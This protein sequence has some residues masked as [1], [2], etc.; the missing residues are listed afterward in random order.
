M[1]TNYLNVIDPLMEHIYTLA[2]THVHLISK[3]T[4]MHCQASRRAAL[5][6]YVIDNTEFQN[7]NAIRCTYNPFYVS[8][9]RLVIC[10]TAY[11]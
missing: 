6:C 11:M 3:C 8:W 2:R 9:H 7:Y 10:T 1:K 4:T 5:D